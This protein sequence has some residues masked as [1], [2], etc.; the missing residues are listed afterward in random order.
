MSASY[1]TDETHAARLLELNEQ[2]LSAGQIAR[3]IGDGCT[4]NMVIGKLK[5]LGICLKGRDSG[6]ALR[7]KVKAARVQ[8]KPRL[9]IVR[10]SSTPAPE[11]I[12]PLGEF[13][14][15]EG[16]RYTPDDVGLPAWRMC[17]HPVYAPG[18]N[19]CIHHAGIVFQPQQ[20]AASRK[21]AEAV[22]T[23]VQDRQMRRMGL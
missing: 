22:D 2:G 8:A 9:S 13:P 15:G 7:E 17:G 5:R 18:T 20:T 12:G 6:G 23:R 10:Q 4:R 3:G 1:W 21:K 19:W 16:C 11:F 14:R